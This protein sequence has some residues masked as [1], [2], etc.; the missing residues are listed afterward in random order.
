MNRNLWQ[1]INTQSWQINN[2]AEWRVA[3]SRLEQV[4]NEFSPIS[5][6]EMDAV[7]LLDRI[8]TKFVLSEE[9]LVKTLAAL[10]YDYRILAVQGQRLNHYRTLYFDTDTF[11]L[12]HLHVNDRGD[13]YKV[14]SREYTDSNISFLEVK[15]KTSK[16]R[17]IKE[18]FSTHQPLVNINFEAENWL[19]NIFP[20]NSREL[21]AKLWNTF[22]RITLVNRKQ[23]ERV[24]L[25]VDLAFYTAQK[26]TRLNGIAVAEV[27]L[28]DRYQA[29]PF[30]AQ[31]RSQHIRP[32]GFSKYCI[33]VSLLYEQVK[34]NALKPRLLA[35][36][37]INQ[38]VYD[39]RF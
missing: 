39:E 36:K 7:A 10:R 25:D 9:Q 27:K 18:R 28:N 19:G 26:Q 2:L 35:I 13:R 33:G 37:K 6:A 34:K 16:D 22:T 15:H 5:L 30:L 20:Y 21:E 12:Y 32:Q 29:S 38:G 1:T 8:D 24:T 14:R 23:C 4:A 31:M 17:T 3:P 11:D